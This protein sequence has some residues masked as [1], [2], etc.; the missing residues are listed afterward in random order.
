MPGFLRLK[1]VLDQAGEPIGLLMAEAIA[2]AREHGA[3][4]LKPITV[5]VGPEGGMEPAELEQFRA[6]GFIAVSLG[7]TVLRFETAAV[8][9]LSVVRAALATLPRTIKA[10]REE[11]LND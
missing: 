6:A 10:G 1:L 11:F 9:A 5:V 7:H 2:N 8:A 4:F 3:G